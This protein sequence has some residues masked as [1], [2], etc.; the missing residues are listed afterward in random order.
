MSRIEHRQKRRGL[1]AAMTAYPGRS[2]LEAVKN[3][4]F[5]IVCHS[6]ASPLRMAF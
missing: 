1:F 5:E 2:G 6:K 4:V 3:F